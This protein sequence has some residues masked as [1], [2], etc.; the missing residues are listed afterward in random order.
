MP[1][2]QFREADVIKKISHV[3]FGMDSPEMMQQ[4]AHIQIIAKN[5]YQD[6]NRE[7]IPYGVLDKKMV[8]MI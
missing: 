3:H 2:E 7:P 8:I 4:E 6:L 1:K 5:L